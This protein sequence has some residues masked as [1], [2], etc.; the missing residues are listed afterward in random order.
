MISI[1]NTISFQV[2]VC[3]KFGLGIKV[4]SKPVFGSELELGLGLGFERGLGL[5]SGFKL[6]LRLG[7]EF[8]LGLGLG[9]QKVVGLG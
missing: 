3:V 2:L 6:A 9:L 1:R 8:I 4:S 5:E 7:F